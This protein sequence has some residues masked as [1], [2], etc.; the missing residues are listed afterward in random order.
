[1]IAHAIGRQAF[2][3]WVSRHSVVALMLSQACLD[4][5]DDEALPQIGPPLASSD[6]AARDR[7]MLSILFDMSEAMPSDRTLAQRYRLARMVADAGADRVASDI[8]VAAMSLGITTRADLEALTQSG[9]TGGLLAENDRRAAAAVDRYETLPDFAN[10][11]RRKRPEVPNTEIA[12]AFVKACHGK[13]DLEAGDE[14]T[15]KELRRLIQAGRVVGRAKNADHGTV[16]QLF[17]TK[18]G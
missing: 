5:P 16:V 8:A 13:G 4:W 14:G 15:L 17:P 18:E 12:R 3:E 11:R 10:A 7:F 9:R 2:T 1:M 6:P